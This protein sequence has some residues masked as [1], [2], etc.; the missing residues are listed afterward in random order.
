MKVKNMRNAV[1]D[2]G[3]N[4]VKLLVAEKPSGAPPSPLLHRLSITR[5][6]EGLESNGRLST[7]AM[8]RTAMTVADFMRQARELNAAA[9]SIVST[10]AARKA[11]NREDFSRI[12]LEI[13][14][15][16]LRILS[17]EEESA[18]GM[19]GVLLAFP[20]FEGLILDIG[21]GSTELSFIR[22]GIVF[23]RCLPIG[24][25]NLHEKNIRSNPP[26]ENE[27]SS[28]EREIQAFLK[29]LPEK[30]TGWDR[31][32]ER[33][34]V[35]MGG[36][37]TT[38]AAIIQG[39][40]RFDG[41]MIHRFYFSG[42]DLKMLDEHLWRSTLQE[43]LAMPGLDPGR[44]DIIPAGSAILRKVIESFGIPGCTVS[45]WNLM[46][47]LIEEMPPGAQSTS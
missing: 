46:H 44:A 26:L 2:I 42:Q 28:L 13:A 5:L 45:T 23:S 14:G 40:E 6:G 34:L 8:R 39:L 12:I 41:E 10:A 4:S 21:G 27:R 17:G 20:G 18:L 15:L 7:E 11:E 22:H 31:G 24:C 38:L 35:G 19:K 29:L 36:T 43:R 9:F 25:V 33:R 37:I 47:A 32:G 1:I 16:P 30:E 3:T